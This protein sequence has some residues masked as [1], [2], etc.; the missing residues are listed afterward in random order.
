MYS[1]AMT[2]QLIKKDLLEMYSHRIC[3]YFE[4]KCRL[5]QCFN[6]QRYEYFERLCKHNQLCVVCVRS[7]HE[8]ICKKSTKKRKCVNCDEN[9][10]V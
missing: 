5:K 7:Y 4:K 9:H 6:C 8:S 3:K 1:E 10:S 2:N